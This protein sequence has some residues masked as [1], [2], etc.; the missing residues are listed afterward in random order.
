M[1][2]ER[3]TNLP[4]GVSDEDEAPVWSEPPWLEGLNDLS[5]VLEGI[6]IALDQP[7]RFT[8]E[9]LTALAREVQEAARRHGVYE[10]LD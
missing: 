10:P 6:H 3:P 5:D 7:E 8:S 2:P 9:Q 4:S 1:S